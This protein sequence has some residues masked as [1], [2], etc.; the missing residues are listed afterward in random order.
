MRGSALALLLLGCSSQSELPPFGEVL[1][2]IDTNVAVPGAI[3]RVRFDLF[4]DD[5]VWLQSGDFA[6]PHASDFPLSMS[7]YN[8]SSVARSVLVRVR[9]YPEGRQRDYL[10]ERF[11]ERPSFEEPSVP[12]SLAEACAAAPRVALGGVASARLPG[13]AFED[14]GVGCGGTDTRSGLVAFEFEAVRAAAHRIEVSDAQPGHDWGFVAN[15]VLSVRSACAAAATE[16]ACNDDANP[17]FSVL[18]G[19]TLDLE[20]GRYFVLVGNVARGP[21]DVTLHVRESDAESPTPEP[22]DVTEEVS[23]EPRLIS[24]GV[25]VTPEREPLPGL[26]IDRLALLRVEPERQATARLLLDGECL[27][28]MADLA[29]SRTCVDHD[30]ELVAADE[31]PLFSGRKRATSSLVGTW[32]GYRSRPCELSIGAADPE[33]F[34]EQVCVDGGAFVLGDPAIIGQGADDGQPERV[35]VLPPF[36]LD[37]FE[38]TVGRYRDARRRGFEPPDSGPLN[39]FEPVVLDAAAPFRSCTWNEA[40][41]GGPLHAGQENLP[42][43]CVSWLTARA[44]CRFD[45][46]DLPTV[47][48]REYAAAA[49]ARDFETLYPWGDSA[50]TCADAVFGRWIDNGTG[51]VECSKAGMGLGLVDVDAEPWASNDRTPSGVV[52]LGGSLAEWTLDSHRAYDD[53]CWQSQSLRSPRCSEE[54]APLHTVMGASFRDAAGRTRSAMRIGGATAGIDP[55]V[56][57]RCRHP[58]LPDQ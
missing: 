20:P 32:S 39:N 9:G 41:A 35:A 19:L 36:Y 55:S 24:D 30:G 46:G 25:D 44:L 22:N 58:G 23:A 11:A 1:L 4:A 26:T 14:G 40:L 15:T 37:R 27:G 34:D 12:A 7:V 31:E 45:A 54:E 17:A 33:L 5:G 38:Y 29:G 57:F 10:G 2:E 42:L 6:T 49:Q 52:A 18:S 8:D 56:G 48:E 43:S 3:G 51:S 47:A 21:M 28:T 13:S 50:P 16:L 53:A